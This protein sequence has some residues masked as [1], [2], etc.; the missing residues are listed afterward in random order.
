MKKYFDYHTEGNKTQ[1]IKV[2]VEYSKGGFNGFTG[3]QERRGIWLYICP[4]T[5]EKMKLGEKDYVSEQY[6]AFSGKKIC[7]R[8]LSRKS[9]KQLDLIVSKVE[10]IAEKLATLFRENKFVEMNTAVSQVMAS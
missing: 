9:D 8:E 5:L 3:G 7:L 10:P 6:I 4:V 1:S 2:E